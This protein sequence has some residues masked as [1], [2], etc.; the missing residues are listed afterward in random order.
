MPDTP[1]SEAVVGGLR[2]PLSPSADAGAAE[3]LAPNRSAAYY[4]LMLIADA[5]QRVCDAMLESAPWPPGFDDE[6]IYNLRAWSCL[7]L[8]AASA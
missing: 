3:T 4:E 1:T 7:T 6:Y 2:P 8:A 5:H